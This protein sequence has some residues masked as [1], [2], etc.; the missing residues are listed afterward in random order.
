MNL[1]PL[2]RALRAETE[3][4]ADRR[5]AEVAAECKRIVAEAELAAQGLV[6]EA[7]L[8]GERAAARETA[9][10]QAGAARRAREASLAAR[11]DLVDELR[12]RSRLEVLELREQPDYP[13]L[14]ER[15]SA[16]ARSQLGDD[17][18]L[19]VD[20][21]GRGGVIARRGEASVDYTLAA[22]AD[23]VIDD[24]GADLERLWT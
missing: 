15:L 19:V 14:L 10:R 4:E 24:L 23:R 6:H 3:A 7:R 1:E 22:M 13:A 11:R 16:A 17:A 8:E 18:E 12:R 20:P 5:R 2:R 21:P 9:R